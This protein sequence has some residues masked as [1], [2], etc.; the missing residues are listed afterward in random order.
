MI[1]NYIFQVFFLSCKFDDI[2]SFQCPYCFGSK[3]TR[4]NSNGFRIWRRAS[5]GSVNTCDDDKRNG[6][7][8]PC[9]GR[10]KKH[11]KWVVNLGEFRNLIFDSIILRVVFS[12]YVS[13]CAHV[14]SPF[15]RDDPLRCRFRCRVEMHEDWYW[16]TDFLTYPFLC[17]MPRGKIYPFV[18]R[19]FLGCFGIPPD[20]PALGSPQFWANS[21]LAVL[22]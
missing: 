13:V 22:R 14:F 19:C 17:W 5:C 8:S 1:F 16:I 2:F 3:K 7:G 4:K 20:G 6:L 12:M 9:D 10:E 18:F 15:R 11:H 21:T